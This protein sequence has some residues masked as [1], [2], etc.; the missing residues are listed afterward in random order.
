MRASFQCFYFESLPVFDSQR[1]NICS[2]YIKGGLLRLGFLHIRSLWYFALHLWAAVHMHAH[3][4]RGTTFGGKDV[5]WRFDL[6]PA[7]EPYIINC[8]CFL[9]DGIKHTSARD[10]LFS[11]LKLR[12]NVNMRQGEK[13]GTRKKNDRLLLSLFNRGILPNVLQAVA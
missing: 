5:G 13:K 6:C 12:T 3:H 9:S 1:P 8:S 10:P 7:F 4:M 11:F 2:I